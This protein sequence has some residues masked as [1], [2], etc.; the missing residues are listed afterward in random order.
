M[1]IYM[2]KINLSLNY[3]LRYRKDMTNLLFWEIWEC[4]IISSKSWYQFVARFYAYQHAE[5]QLHHPLLS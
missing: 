3:F 5:N 2:Q 4:L 1:F